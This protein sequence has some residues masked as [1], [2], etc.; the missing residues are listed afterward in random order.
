[1]VILMNENSLKLTLSNINNKLSLF[2]RIRNKSISL[3][4]LSLISFED[5]NK[6]FVETNRIMEGIGTSSFTLLDNGNIVMSSNDSILMVWDLNSYQRKEFFPI[7][8]LL[9]IMMLFCTPFLVIKLI[10]GIK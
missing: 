2:K 5:V 4:I 7:Q 3:L 9:E 10:Y 8:G 6:S 1:M